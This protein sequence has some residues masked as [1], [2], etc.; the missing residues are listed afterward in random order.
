MARLSEQKAI[1]NSQH[2]ALKLMDDETVFTRVPDLTS[3]SSSVP[4]T[5][6]TDTHPNTV[7]N[8]RP[9]S[10]TVDQTVGSEE[11]IRLKMELAEAQAKIT[12]LEQS[13]QP[14]SRTG[15]ANLEDAGYPQP[16]APIAFGR[17]ATW[18][19]EEEYRN[20][21]DGIAGAAEHV[22]PRGLSFPGKTPFPVPAS[23]ANAS[24]GPNG[25]NWYGQRQGFTHGFVDP[26]ASYNMADGY[27][28]DRHTPDSDLVSRPTG[29]RRG[30]RYD[31]FGTPAPANSYGGGF[32]GS[33]QFDHMAGHHLGNGVAPA[34]QG[35]AMN[36]YTPYG[37]QQMGTSLSPHATEFTSGVGW[38]Y[39]V[40]TSLLSI[41]I[42]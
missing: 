1:L 15:S 36:V 37:A 23:M 10:A 29:G 34:P 18:I 26:A 25:G 20:I 38:K 24:D 7:P 5:P 35:M 2:D 41:F 28:N 12:Q 17:A 14:Q 3:S 9:A 21:G 33:A 13:S 30:N 6:A 22:P 11:L 32:Q 8:T 39:E 42:V 40:S 19:Q 4:V 31:R 27:R 16:V